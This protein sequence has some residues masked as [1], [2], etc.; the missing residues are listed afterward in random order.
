MSQNMPFSDLFKKFAPYIS[1]AASSFPVRHR[2]DLMQE[3]YLGLYQAC[4]SYDVD[5][6]VPFN[7]F[8]KICIKHRMLTAYKSMG[9]DDDTLVLDEALIDDRRTAE[10]MEAKDFFN[11]LRKNLTDLERNVLDEYL[12]DLSYDQ[13]A[14]NLNI[15]QKK[16]DNTI[17]RV[18]RKIKDKYTF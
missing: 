10:S 4:G 11:N 16:V 12:K 5:K 3:G 18:K 1:Y 15:T 7:A 6:D 8:A 14:K 17:S 9:K 2:E 13:I